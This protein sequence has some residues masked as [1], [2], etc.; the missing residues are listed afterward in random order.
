MTGIL[1]TIKKTIGIAQE[2]DSFDVQVL[3]TW[4]PD[5]AMNL[6]KPDYLDYLAKLAAVSG[7]KIDSFKSLLAVK[8]PLISLAE[9][10]RKCSFCVFAEIFFH[11][12]EQCLFQVS[13]RNV[14]VDI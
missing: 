7:V 6:E 8:R 13:E 11:E 4:R 5:K 14:F 3:P 2:D 9:H 12:V 10:K 1:A